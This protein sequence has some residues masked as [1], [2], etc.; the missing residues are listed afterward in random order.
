VVAKPDDKC[1]GEWIPEKM[2][3]L[4]KF[5]STL[6]HNITGMDFALARAASYDVIDL[7]FD[8]QEHC[9]F[10]E[11]FIAIYRYCKGEGHCEGSKVLAEMSE[12]AF[13]LITKVS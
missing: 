11:S 6:A 8:N 7:I 13:S 3:T 10:S 1:F 4:E 12:N 2:K 5:G 9:H